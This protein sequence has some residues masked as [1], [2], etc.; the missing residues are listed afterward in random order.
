[1]NNLSDNQIGMV[2]S[3]VLKEVVIKTTGFSLDDAGV[4]GDFDELIG[5]MSLNG[6]HH[7]LVVI[8][9]K[10]DTIKT[11]SSA[12]TGISINDVTKDDIYDTLCELV[13]MTAG[14][15][16]LRFNSSEDI[17]MLSPPFIVYGAD[18]SIVSKNRVNFISKTLSGD[19]ITL[20]LK[21][22]FY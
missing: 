21:V 18:M 6:Y 13:N 7:G 12:M 9:A 19:G 16:K 8:S 3:E 10:Y 14:N 15:A 5:L 2:F 4:S 1:M 11:L 17:Y 20:N 22:V